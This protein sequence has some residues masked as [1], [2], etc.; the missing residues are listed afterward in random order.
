MSKTV[1]CDRCSQEIRIR[2]DLVTATMFFQVVPYHE[3]CYAKDL[4][5]AKTLILNNQ[6]I[7]GFSG[8]FLT[9]IA[10]VVFILSFFINDETMI[11]LSILSAIPI[12]YRLYSFIIYERH[13]EK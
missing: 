3:D 6:P 11:Y 8:N 13:L 1:H 12:I 7:N 4:K 9:F 2:G 5:G 10:I